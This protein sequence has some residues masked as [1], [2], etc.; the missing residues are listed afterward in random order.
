MPLMINLLEKS[1]TRLSE[2]PNNLN[3][4]FIW[5]IIRTIETVGETI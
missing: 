5:P 1:L 2:P 3:K 4:K